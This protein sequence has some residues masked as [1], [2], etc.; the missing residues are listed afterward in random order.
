[1]IYVTIRQRDADAKATEPITTGSVG[2]EAGF[3]FSEDWRELGKTAVFRGSGVQV[4]A[5]LLTERCRVPHEVLT[6]SGGHLKI[7][8]YG[9]GESGQRVTPTVW[10]DAGEIR[11]GA[12]PAGIEETPA[13][14]SLLQ[15]LLEAAQSARQLAQSVRDDADSGAFD[16][17]AGPAGAPGPAGRDG[18]AGQTGPRGTGIWQ[19]S[20]VYELQPGSGYAVNNFDLAGMSGEP[21]EGD[22]VVYAGNAGTMLF[23]ISSA[24]GQSCRLIL[25]AELTGPQGPQGPA[26]T[27]TAADRAEIVDEV[28]DA[29]PTW[30]GGSY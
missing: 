1:M 21:R 30:T 7:G 6:R 16:G 25:A 18:A 10:A 2:L 26:Y 23:S 8:V 27:L 29:L 12:E 17:A 24:A 19:A 4:D 22:L 13:T 11:E 9:T 14:A 28:L 5:A 15:Q 3:C 20:T